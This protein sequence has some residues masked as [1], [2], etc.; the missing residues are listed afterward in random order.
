MSWQVF[1]S[2]ITTGHRYE[3]HQPIWKDWLKDLHL[4]IG[5]GS[6]KSPEVVASARW[7]LS[8]IWKLRTGSFLSSPGSH[9]TT[10]VKGQPVGIAAS[11]GGLL[12]IETEPMLCLKVV[13]EPAPEGP[14]YKDGEAR[15]KAY[16]HLRALR[17]GLHT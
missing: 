14:W 1:S 12:L 13:L 10:W 4:S 7:P 5:E 9:R 2:L 17:H 3:G 11:D 8:S 16:Q 15:Q 6:Y